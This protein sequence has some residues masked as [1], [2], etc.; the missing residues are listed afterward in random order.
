MALNA[1]NLYVVTN[2]YELWVKHFW[3]AVATFVLYFLLELY[4]MYC[5]VTE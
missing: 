4:N 5:F 1:K 2:V 3:V